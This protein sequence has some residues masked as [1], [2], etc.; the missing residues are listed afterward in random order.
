VLATLELSPGERP[1]AWATD[2]AGEWYV[3]SNLALHLPGADDGPRRVSWELVERVDWARDTDRLAIVEIAEPDGPEQITVAQIDE[4]GRLL[5][6]IRE[7]VTKSI[8]CSVYTRIHRSA[9]VSVVGRRSPSGQGPVRWTSVLS[10]GLDPRDP[11]VVELTEA[12]LEQARRE[13]AGL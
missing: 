12:T 9:G 11:E 4:P 10:A 2:T 13:L 7:R 5:E 6:L 8:V 3:G 1:L